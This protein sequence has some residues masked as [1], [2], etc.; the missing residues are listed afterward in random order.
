[1][2]SARESALP[3]IAWS[4]VF[5]PLTPDDWRAEAW[6]ALDLPETFAAH[7]DEFWSA[8]QVGLPAPAVPLLLHAALG[9]EGGAVREDWMR[10]FAHLGLTWGERALPPDHIGAVC[11][12][13]ACAIERNDAV[14]V[15]EIRKRYL[16]PWCAVARTRLGEHSAALRGIPDAFAADLGG[17][18]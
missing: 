1:M 13:L 10:V 15:Q 14:L 2:I 18:S 4:R 5:S 12:A 8:F 16:E 3:F 6:Q 7:E 17:V 9:R 11:E